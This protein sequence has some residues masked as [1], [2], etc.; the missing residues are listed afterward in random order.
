MQ[1]G[2]AQNVLPYAQ[3]E[4]R[5]ALSESGWA[6]PL[7]VALGYL[8]RNGVYLRISS[9]VA[10]PLTDRADLVLDLLGPTFLQTPDKT[11]FALAFGV[12]ASVEL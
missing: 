9:G 2:R 7:R 3:I 8:P 1:G 5:I 10:V 4:Q 6:I 11:L 12:E